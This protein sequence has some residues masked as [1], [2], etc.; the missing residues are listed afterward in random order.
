MSQFRILISGATGFIG[1]NVMN[2][3][4]SLGY[5]VDTISTQEFMSE[6]WSRL[7]DFKLEDVTTPTHVVHCA[8]PRDGD[9]QSNVHMEFAERTTNFFDK[10]A[11]RGV[12]VINIGSSSEYG[13]KD[14]AMREDMICE[15]ISTYGIAKLAT[16]LHAKRHG[17]NT[18][19]VFTAYGEGGHSFKDIKDKAK[20]WAGY[21]NVRHYISVEQ[22]AISVERLLHAKH[23]YGEIINLAASAPQHNCNLVDSPDSDENWA[24]MWFEYP[25]R[26]YEPSEWRADLTKM[27]KLINI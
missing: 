13:P 17:F 26:Q 2:Y 15:P 20:K 24:N 14:E 22:V 23:L 5:E 6:D 3:L 18:L 12:K 9:L 16:T 19:R 10:C 4:D 21:S 8:W 27:K 1:K 11:S 25:Q 7:Y